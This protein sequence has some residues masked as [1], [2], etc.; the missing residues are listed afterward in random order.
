MNP[1]VQFTEEQIDAIMDALVDKGVPEEWACII[2][3]SVKIKH[4]SQY[5]F[6]HF[7]QMS[8]YRVIEV[9][10]IWINTPEG[11]EW[12]RGVADALRSEQRQ[13]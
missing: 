6:Q 2:A 7:L 11:Y 5:K 9:G 4:T 3:E 13:D 12:W 1:F 10:F 8:P